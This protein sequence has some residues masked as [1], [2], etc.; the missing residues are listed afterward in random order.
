[1]EAVAVRTGLSDGVHT[2][3]LHGVAVGDTLVVGLSIQTG[4]DD[5]GNRSFLRGNQAQY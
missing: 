3:L 5:G 2:E 4:A 1:M